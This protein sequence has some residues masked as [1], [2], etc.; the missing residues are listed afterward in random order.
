MPDPKGE[1]K[2]GWKVEQ[3]GF[4]GKKKEKGSRGLLG[5]QISS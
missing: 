3:V 1:R 5:S 2:A 4:S